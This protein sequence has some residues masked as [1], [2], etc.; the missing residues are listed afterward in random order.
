[1]VVPGYGASE[2]SLSDQTL[3]SRIEPNWHKGLLNGEPWPE[4]LEFL[5]SLQ[6]SASEGLWGGGGGWLIAA[7]AMGASMSMASK[8]RTQEA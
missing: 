8:T 4:G 2:I 7:S 6:K 3:G 5:K 1:M